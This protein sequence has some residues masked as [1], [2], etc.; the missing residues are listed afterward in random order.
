M[1]NETKPSHEEL[2]EAYNT[3]LRNYQLLQFDK[4]N[5]K[6]HLMM[7]VINSGASEKAKK[8]AE[9]HLEQLLAKP[10]TK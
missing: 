7:D 2:M 6:V 10:K 9:W 8:L 5:E 4:A 3:L 1:E